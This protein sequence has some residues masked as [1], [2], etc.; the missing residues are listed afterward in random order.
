MR[1][2]DPEDPDL[3]TLTDHGIHTIM[4]TITFYINKNTLLSFY[5]EDTINNKMKDL[6]TALTDYLFMNYE[7][8]F[9]MPTQEECK[10]VLIERLRK[11]Q[12][13]ILDEGELR[14]MKLNPDAVWKKLINDITDYEKEI[15][16]IKEQKMKDKLK[17]FE[18]L[19][20]TVQDAIHS[21]YLRALYGQERRTLRQHIHVTE[22]LGNNMNQ[23]NQGS[24]NPL[25]WVRGNVGK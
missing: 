21:T 4:N 25:S 9:Q 5:D 12:K 17:K 18:L 7:K 22:S 11:K 3:V 15:I 23:Q 19:I 13:T 2:T 24:F 14:G 8:T 20:R 16:K 6:A 1:W 10:K